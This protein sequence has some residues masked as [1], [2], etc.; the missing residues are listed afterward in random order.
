MGVPIGG[1]SRIQLNLEA[2]KADGVPYLGKIKDGMILPLMWMEAAID[3]IPDPVLNI[4][5]HAYY[6][7]NIVDLSFKWGS[8]IS[9]ILSLA[10]L[11]HILRKKQLEDH[12][13]LHRNTSGQNPLLE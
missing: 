4:L 8:I 1:H 5:S 9:L 2:R 3:N 13:V 10:S 11:Y 12:T 6:T 7:V